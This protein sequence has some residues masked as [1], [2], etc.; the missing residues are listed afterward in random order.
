MR[1]E[2]KLGVVL[3]V[4][5]V[6]VVPSMAL[7]AHPMYPPVGDAAWFVQEYVEDG[8][9]W[10]SNVTKSIRVG[11]CHGQLGTMTIKLYDPSGTLRQT[12]TANR[13]YTPTYVYYNLNDH[14]NN[15]GVIAGKWHMHWNGHF[16]GDPV[17]GDEYMWVGAIELDR[18]DSVPYNYNEAKR[19][20]FGLTFGSRDGY[21]VGASMGVTFMTLQNAGTGDHKLLIRVCSLFQDRKPYGVTYSNNHIE[22]ITLYVRKTDWNGWG[23]TGTGSD[24]SRY[25]SGIG[26]DRAFGTNVTITGGYVMDP[27]VSD[28][29]AGL[30]GALVTVLIPTFPLLGVP[31]AFIAGAAMNAISADNPVNASNH[32]GW[33][34]LASCDYTRDTDG[35]YNATAWTNMTLTFDYQK[36]LSYAFE[37][38]T[39]FEYYNE[40]WPAY[41]LVKS[42]PSMYIVIDNH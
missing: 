42:T 14:F 35:Y 3:F 30:I 40:N 27:Y 25:N 19:L 28:A 26:V 11:Y 5:T 31:A 24:G 2:I 10:L 33:H 9:K 36:S 38:Y 17:Y 34:S 39:V 1:R 13:A 8:E 32:D 23:T 41:T 6:M 21:G 4:A 20:G 22:S 12:W 16:E 15:T 18:T 29:T 7:G 37:I